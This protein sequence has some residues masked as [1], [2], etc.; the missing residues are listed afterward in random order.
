[1][2]L[3]EVYV[4]LKQSKRLWPGPAVTRNEIS[5]FYASVTDMDIFRA[6]IDVASFRMQVVTTYL[7]F[8]TVRIG[9]GWIIYY[10][11][12]IKHWS[13]MNV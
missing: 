13:C 9:D 7:G 2:E 8:I 1:M 4:Q 11:Q 3:H 6:I 10:V 5:S 12:Y